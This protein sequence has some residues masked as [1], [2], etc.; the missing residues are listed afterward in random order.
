MS[1]TPGKIRIIGGALKGHS[2]KV[3]KG[4]MVRPM[5]SRIRESL[6]S[7]LGDEVRGAR[8]LDGFA[9][10]GAIG[11]EAASRGA[12]HVLFVENAPAVLAVLRRNLDR[13]ALG[14]RALIANVDLYHELPADFGPFEVI[15]LD[16]PFCDYRSAAHDPW[17]LAFRLARNDAVCPGGVV[18][19]EAP[20][21]LRPPAAPPELTEEVDRRFGDTRIVL[22]RSVCA[23]P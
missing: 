5:R 2:L 4:R 10:S 16:P 7:I 22:W 3:P 19:V 14:P 20:A 12:R 17:Q 9:G 23:I 18:G 21:E 6:F 11:C 13:L 1:P 8:F 15:F